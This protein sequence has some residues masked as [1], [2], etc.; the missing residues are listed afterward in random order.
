MIATRRT[1]ILTEGS[2]APFLPIFSTF[3][4]VND[5]RKE[6]IPTLMPVL[7]ICIF[8]WVIYPG[9]RIVQKIDTSGLQ[10]YK[11]KKDYWEQQTISQLQIRLAG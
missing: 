7:A 10:Y 9:S 1:A 8:L 2:S 4:Y 6:G 11:A 5:G 3:Q